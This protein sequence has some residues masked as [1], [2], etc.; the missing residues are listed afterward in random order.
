MLQA[1]L[2]KKLAANDIRV[3]FSVK[4]N[5][6]LALYG[7]SGSGK[8]SVINMLAGLLKPSSGKIIFNGEWI[9]NSYLKIDIPSEKRRFGYVF[10]EGR[11]FPHFSV[12][13]NLN[14]GRKLVRNDRRKICFDEVIHL[15]RIE[16]LLHRFPGKLSGGEKQRVA[17]GRALLMSP[18]LL[19]MDEPLASLDLKMKQELLPFISEISK[20][21]SVPIIY[22]SH[23]L[24]EIRQLTDDILIVK[25]GLAVKKRTINETG[26]MPLPAASFDL[27]G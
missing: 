27:V 26:A 20:T 13:T 21:M 6:I 25:N 8:T 1:T 18:N 10:Q 14:Y 17:I 11:L 15:L 12:R 16:K 7:P 22:V 5:G 3:N 23:S 9:Y 4:G 2:H 24:E 19:L